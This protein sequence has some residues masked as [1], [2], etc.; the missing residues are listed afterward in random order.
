[1]KGLKRWFFIFVPVGVLNLVFTVAN[2]TGLSSRQRGPGQLTKIGS[3]SR[4]VRDNGVELWLARCDGVVRPR[5]GHRARR[6]GV[7]CCHDGGVSH[8]QTC[9][10]SAPTS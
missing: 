5:V 7:G 1:M 10:A 4:G 2:K 3:A 6:G 8:G 9:R